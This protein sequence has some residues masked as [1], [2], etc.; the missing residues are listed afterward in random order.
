MEFKLNWLN[1]SFFSSA[2]TAAISSPRISIA[3][4]YQQQSF[5]VV[6]K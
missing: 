5:T 3:P 4:K 1:F 2:K 6:K